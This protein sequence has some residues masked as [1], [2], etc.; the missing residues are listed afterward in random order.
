M[1][2]ENGF[3]SVVKLSGNRRKPYAARL[4]LG[5]KNGKQQRKYI[6]YYKTKKE[7]IMAL[8]EYH[9]HGY[10]L[11]SYKLTL[12]EV[13][14]RWIKRLESKA[15]KNVLSSHQMAYSRFGKMEDVPLINLKADQLQD[16]M[17][18]IDLKPGSKRRIKSTMIQLFKYAIMN[19][20]VHTNYA[21]H[22]EITEKT[23]KVGKVFTD[24]EIQILWNNIDN[25]TVQWI[26][27]LLYTGM[28]I[29][30]LLSLT[31]DTIYLDEHYMVGGSKTEAGKDRIIPLHESIVPL[32][33]KQLGNAR[34]LIRD[35]K[36]RKMSYQKALKL[37]KA[38]M[39]ELD[40]YDHNPHDTRKTAVSIMH[41]ANIPMETI[42]IIVGH[43][44][45]GI[46]ETVYLHKTPQELVEAI[47][48]IKIDI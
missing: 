41:G 29:G 3:G 46:T 48:Q 28:R 14:D 7:A 44:G 33:E 45:K 15:S 12:G 30:E 19:D 22:I 34:P 2:A 47:N 37:F 11:D 43:S 39:V 35:E 38:T 4:T 23:E 24:E 31:S 16:W 18:G 17:D 10:N 1:R 25:S 26:I 6:G 27:I 9:H 13:Y 42:R 20:I 8:A 32:V 21:E 5:W 40:L 36:G